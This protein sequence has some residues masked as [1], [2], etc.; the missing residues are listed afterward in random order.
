[1]PSIIHFLPRAR[2]RIPAICIVVAVLLI[3]AASNLADAQVAHEDPGKVL[4][5]KST[6]SNGQISI[7]LGH[8]LVYLDNIS[9]GVQTSNFTQAWN[10][11]FQFNQTAVKLENMI[12]QLNQ[13]DPD[14]DAISGE[15]NSTNVELAAFIISSNSYN[16]TR[17]QY[18]QAVAG[19]DIN[20]VSLYR[21]L[22]N[23]RYV[24]TVNSYT[25]ISSNVSDLS[26]LLQGKNIDTR[27]LQDSLNHFNSYIDW[28][29][30]DYS[31]LGIGANGS[32]LHCGA[33]QSVS[34]VGGDVRLSAYLVDSQSQPMNNSS[35]S[36]YIDNKLLGSNTT[37]NKGLC[38]IDYFVP[39][40][41]EQDELHIQAEYM[42]VGGGIP[43][44]YSN[45]VLLHVTDLTT[46]I[47]MSLDKD[48]ASYG[49]T[50]AIFGQLSPLYGIYAGGRP[51]SILFGDVPA[52]T[53]VTTDNGSYEYDLRIAS[54]TLS[55]TYM[56][57]AVYRPDLDDIL[58]GAVSDEV[59]LNIT[60]QNT[61]VTLSGPAFANLGDATVFNG[62]LFSA[63]GKPVSG[64]NVS[65]YIDGRIAGNGITD[66]SGIYGISAVIPDNATAGVHAIFAM[67]YP[68]F[69]R[70]LNGSTSS[71]ADIRFNDTGKKIDVQGVPLVLFADDHLNL[72]GTIFSG[73]GAPIT[74]KA[75]DISAI[76]LN[77]TM[78]ITDDA[79]GFNTSS[80]FTGGILP[81]LS[82]VTI[83][84]AESSSI[85]YERQVLLIP[86]DMWKV[87]GAIVILAAFISG[88]FVIVRRP[89]ARGQPQ[90]QSIFQETAAGTSHRPEFD[91]DREILQI[92]AAMEKNDARSALIQIYAAVRKA[93]ALA[94]VAVTDSMT[95][96]GFYDKTA[97]A[98]PR[99]A[100]P[101]RYILNSYQS[102]IDAR[103]AFST[104][105][106]E[107][108]LKCLLY[109]NRE[110]MASQGA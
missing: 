88:A 110:L 49:D 38:Y 4:P 18:D 72:T 48:E 43:P 58:M 74:N 83:S 1:M 79:G 36:F 11:Y 5:S 33:N 44:I 103:R 20:N 102:S 28:L 55:G 75:L 22:L 84:D 104:T 42:P 63:N 82:K 81:V 10:A 108:A 53:T 25:N 64:A 96:D 13:S 17:L 9:A 61:N 68:V 56:I 8:S 95:E 106:L 15:L 87:L 66:D 31:S 93:V 35:V 26:P 91:I 105:E 34:Y 98:F 54:D 77:A 65:L 89:G 109:I 14:Y 27:P 107:M 99:V 30:E 100:P 39:A 40:T 52:G 67:F 51:I 46:S 32:V 2:G 12:W 69:G 76:G 80:L 21:V 57:N 41:V 90:N 78:A 6:S 47:S 7:Q 73:A 85:L 50:V 23:D 45:P 70:S 92:M 60:T 97:A 94:G 101:L 3:L 86:F 71:S 37:N 59:S 19:S 16:T 29:N 62:T 24:R